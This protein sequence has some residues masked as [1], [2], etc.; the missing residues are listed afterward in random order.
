MLNLPTREA[1]NSHPNSSMWE[2]GTTEKHF[3]SFHLLERLPPI[4]LHATF[5]SLVARIHVLRYHRYT[6]DRLSVKHRNARAHG[7]C[8][9]SISDFVLDHHNHSSSVQ[10]P[11]SRAHAGLRDEGATIL[12]GAVAGGPGL[13]RRSI[14]YASLSPADANLLRLLKGEC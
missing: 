8:D 11:R 7:P 10:R 2:C 13:H 12:R 14:A 5:V 6:V 1:P 9:G 4:S 3:I